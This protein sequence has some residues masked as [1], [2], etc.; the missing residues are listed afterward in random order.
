M[1]WNSYVT[2]NSFY[3]KDGMYI[4][5]E[6]DGFV[7]N[8]ELDGSTINPDIALKSIEELLTELVKDGIEYVRAKII[9]MINKV[10]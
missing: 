6:T 2:R 9:K 10:K 1:D 7:K 3:K 4:L 8:N 5:S